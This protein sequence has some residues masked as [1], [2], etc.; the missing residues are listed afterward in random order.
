MAEWLRQPTGDSEGKA[1]GKRTASV[2]WVAVGFVTTKDALADASFPVVY[3]DA[4]PDY[5]AASGMRCNSIRIDATGF[6]VM[7]V[8][9]NYA[10]PE[11]GDE[12]DPPEPSLTNATIYSWQTVQESV[13]I[14]RD[15]AGN[16]IVTSAGRA[17]TGIT[18][19]MNYKRLTITR[20]ESSYNLSQA[21]TYEN[22]V[23]ADTFEGAAG[24]SVKC[25]IIQPSTQ[26]TALS[27]TI[28]IDYMFDFK[29]PT[30]WGAYP[31][32]LFITDKD[33]WALCTINSATQWVRIVGA[34]GHPAGDVPLNGQGVPLSG[35]VTYFE[36]ATDPEP[37]GSPS[38]VTQATPTGATVVTAGSL[39]QLRWMVL[40]EMVFSGLGF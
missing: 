34:D 14:D 36:R 25:S 31:W 9:A 20:W 5:S 8:T 32:R 39:K 27:A 22:T 16:A 17:V 24:G 30:V 33:S 12:H 29:S 2:R 37:K 18:R 3:N 6:K 23:N 35:Y 10:F 4:H 11:N 26:Y 7:T 28:P 1:S 40:P 21:L 15:W 38:W 13:Q 19:P